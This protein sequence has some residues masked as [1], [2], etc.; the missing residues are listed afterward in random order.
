MLGDPRWET[1]VLAAP[2]ARPFPLL[3]L[4]MLRERW[5]LNKKKYTLL[6]GE[7]YWFLFSF[8][9]FSSPYFCLFL[10]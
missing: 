7:F 9:L 4:E 6:T 10:S 1:Q 2:P 3:D 5:F 8:F